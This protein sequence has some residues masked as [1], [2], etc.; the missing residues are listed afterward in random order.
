MSTA[1]ALK[2]VTERSPERKALA[3]VI[4]AHRHAQRE[5]Q[6]CRDASEQASARW[7]QVRRAL[8]A[9][10]EESLQAKAE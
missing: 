5:L 6:D 9:L 4:E 10:Y 3:E 7:W 8:D 2:I 1:K